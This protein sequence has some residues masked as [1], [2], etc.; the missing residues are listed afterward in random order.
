MDTTT[1]QN[2]TVTNFLKQ[3]YATVLGSIIQDIGDNTVNYSRISILG[4]RKNSGISK[5]AIPLAT[6]IYSGLEH[7]KKMLEDGTS[8][9]EEFEV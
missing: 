7:P 2:S 8:M 9:Y 6:C 1:A 3:K 4:D 5:L